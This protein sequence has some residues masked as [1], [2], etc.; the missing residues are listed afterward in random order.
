M[1]CGT[2]CPENAIRYSPASER[3]E[4]LLDPKRNVALTRRGLFAG[5][6]AGFV[7]GPLLKPSSDE[8]PG[9]IRPPGVA[10]E[11]EFLS[12]C[13]R[14]AECV[15]VCPSAGLRP[16]GFETGLSGLWAPRLVPRTG[17]CEYTCNDCGK[18][19]PTGAIPNLSLVEKQKAVLGLA[20]IDKHRCIPW[21]EG[22]PCVVCEEFCP[23]P[24]KAIKLSHE[25][26]T[27]KGTVKAVRA[28]KVVEK[29]CIGCGI[30]ETMCP[31]DGP[32]A[33]RIFPSPHPSEKP[34]RHE[35]ARSTAAAH[36][37]FRTGFDHQPPASACKIS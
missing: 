31:V 13:I 25:K 9:V 16:T 33:I 17:Y 26:I 7:I 19:C 30:C 35:S 21:H 2:E 4:P 20:R 32:A 1:E 18:V 24:T 36:R 22:E 34:V 11:R 8:N 15:R 10:S 37:D 3:D 6:I 14:C 5:T 23:T 12:R 27:V 28:P 29:D